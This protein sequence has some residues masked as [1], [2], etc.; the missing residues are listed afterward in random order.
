MQKYYQ[1]RFVINNAS[2][3]VLTITKTIKK[4]TGCPILKVHM[5]AIMFTRE[6]YLQS[7]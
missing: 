4:K 7:F 3:T 2:I 1:S 6:E 5:W